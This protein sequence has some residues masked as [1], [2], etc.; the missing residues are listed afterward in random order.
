MDNYSVS[1]EAKHD[2]FRSWL[3]KLR[4]PFLCIPTE[5]CHAIDEILVPF[6]DK[7]NLYVYMPAK[8]HK[9]E[10]QDLGTCW[11]KWLNDFDVYQGAKRPD[12]VKWMLQ[13]ML[14]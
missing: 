7:S 10:F 5:E 1:D 14:S 12:R 2:R 4:E 13:E 8:P 11:K 6:K 9:L 3:Q